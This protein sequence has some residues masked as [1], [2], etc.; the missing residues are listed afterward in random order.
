MNTK[1]NGKTPVSH[2]VGRGAAKATMGTLFG[3]GRFAY[4]A[5][6]G[7]IAGAVEAGRE[8][9]RGYQEGKAEAK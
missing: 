3:L 9:K 7:F 5:G 1:T 2:K 8:I 4:R 6:S